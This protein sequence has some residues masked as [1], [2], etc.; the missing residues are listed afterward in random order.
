MA[1]TLKI[2]G[3][4]RSVDVEPDTPL[5]WVI[6][7][8]LGTGMGAKPICTTDIFCFAPPDAP[9]ESLPR[10]VLHPRLVM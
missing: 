5:L 9:P 3:H 4:T 2:N 1:I 8:T 7:D 10:G 6:R